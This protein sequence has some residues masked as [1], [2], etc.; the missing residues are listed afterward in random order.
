MEIYIL[1]RVGVEAKLGSCYSQLPT[2][3]FV[4]SLRLERSTGMFRV[5]TVSSDIFWEFINIV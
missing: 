1:V 5:L 3:T 2:I 4:V